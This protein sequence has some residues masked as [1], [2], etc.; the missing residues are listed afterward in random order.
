MI[1]VKLAPEHCEAITTYCIRHGVMPSVLMREAA[2]E[3]VKSR[4][5]TG[6]AAVHGTTEIDTGNDAKAF[7]LH[8]KITVPLRFTAAQAK[9]VKTW[10]LKRSI[11]LSTF[12]REVVLLTIG[13]KK[14]GVG[15]ILG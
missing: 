12:L 2:L 11:P 13:A 9:D 10:C 1:G 8:G 6:V 4:H 3:H 14:L 15:R 5:G 7:G